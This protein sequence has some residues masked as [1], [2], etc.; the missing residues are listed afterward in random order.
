[1]DGAHAPTAAGC[2]QK[3]LFD[4]MKHETT[5]HQQ[6]DEAKLRALFEDLLGDW[7]RGGVATFLIGAITDRLWRIF[8]PGKKGA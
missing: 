4:L 8:A 1:M 3:G 7:G 6:T 5:T 2:N